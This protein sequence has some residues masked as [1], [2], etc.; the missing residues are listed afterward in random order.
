MTAPHGLDARAVARTV[1][2]NLLVVLFLLIAWQLIAALCGSLLLPR[3]ADVARA[4][5]RF[6]ASGN[7]AAAIASTASLAFLG[8]AAGQ[9]TASLL[10]VVPRAPGMF[11]VL[12]F[13]GLACFVMAILLGPWM[14]ILLAALLG[15]GYLNGLVYV[16]ATIAVCQLFSGARCKAAG[17]RL[18]DGIHAMLPLA[19]LLCIMHERIAGG[20]GLGAV[21]TS[22]M[23]SFDT[24]GV[25]SLAIVNLLVL[26]GMG[27]VLRA[28]IAFRGPAP[29]RSLADGETT[30]S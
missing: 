8:C 19:Y 11:P 21:M 24:P 2:A 13:N 9:V 7:A 28:C 12:R 20:P 1:L 27:L 14:T 23:A 5:G 6:L 30:Y 29:R 18:L 4:L 26:T 22:M 10:A 16:A 25:L 15:L 17:A 3:P